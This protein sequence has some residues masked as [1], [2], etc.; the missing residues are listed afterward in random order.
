MWSANTLA[1]SMWG[2]RPHSR[3]QSSRMHPTGRAV[4]GARSYARPSTANAALPG[5]GEPR[6]LHPNALLPLTLGSEITR[7]RQHLTSSRP[8]TASATMTSL[9]HTPRGLLRGEA[10]LARGGS[11]RSTIGSPRNSPRDAAARSPRR[12]GAKSRNGTMSSWIQS[13][14]GSGRTLTYKQWSSPDVIFDLIDNDGSG[15]VTKSELRAFFRGSPLDPTKQEE[16]FDALDIDGSGEVSREEWRQG[17]FAAGFDGGA[18]VGQ[19]TEGLGVLLG[20]VAAP[21]LTSFGGTQI[22]CFE[23]AASATFGML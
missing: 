23:G 5:L 11:A 22:K 15:S 14:A 18:I 1:V 2:D 19:S 8:S 12:R 7:V 6:V 21:R 13:H 17:Y 20:L 16:L 4:G 9:A 10:A 3:Q